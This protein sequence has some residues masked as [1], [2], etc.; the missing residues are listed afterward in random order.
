MFILKLVK[1]KHGFL[2]KPLFPDL[3]ETT[4]LTPASIYLSIYLSKYLSFLLSIDLLNSVFIY[5]TIRIYGWLVVSNVRI[6]GI[7]K[8][9]NFSRVREIR[10]SWNLRFTLYRQTVIKMPESKIFLLLLPLLVTGEWLNIYFY[11]FLNEI[12]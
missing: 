4:S 1:T 8:S 3:N 9:V 12:F 11:K 6:F 7:R 2:C 10:E 5:P